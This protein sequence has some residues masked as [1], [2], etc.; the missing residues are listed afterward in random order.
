M[1]TDA[2]RL[3]ERVAGY[4]HAHERPSSA[5]RPLKLATIDV[6]YDEDTYPGGTLP[7][8]IF[9]GETILSAKRYVVLPPYWPHP[10]DRVVLVPVGNSYVIIGGLSEGASVHLAG[11]IA[12]GDPA[13]T[14]PRML[15]GRD[16]ITF[17][18]STN[19]SSAL[20]NIDFFRASFTVTFPDDFFLTTPIITL[21]ARTS[22]PGTLIEVSYTNESKDGFDV[23]AA[24]ST[25]TATV[26]DWTAVEP[27]I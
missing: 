23:V 16:T 10:G 17:P 21:A 2:L 24:R 22:V 14:V 19:A 4:T 7:R 1:S 18:G 3:L 26:V 6:D 5:N 11:S 27:L 12:H 13:A 25:D 20:Y 9:D 15:S 8:V